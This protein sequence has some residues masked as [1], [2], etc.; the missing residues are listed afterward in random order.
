M[1]DIPTPTS[2]LEETRPIPEAAPIA[3]RA[4]TILWNFASLS[5]ASVF[6]RIAS[7]ATNAVLG[8]RI[9][10]SGYGVA[11]IAQTVTL[12]FSLLSELGLGTVAVRE[13][14]Q[15]PARLQCTISSMLGLRLVL[16]L[17]MIPFGLLTAQ[18]LPYS[19]SSRNLFRIY[20]FTLPIQAFEVEWVFR[21]VQ[22]MYLNTVL[23]VSASL[24]TFVLTVALIQDSR[25]LIRV[26]GIA[27][28]V[29]GATVAL[30][31]RLLHREG[32]NAWPEFS[33]REFRYLLGQS[34]PLCATSLAVTL[35]S[36]VNNL[37]LGYFR[38]D[39]DVGM[40]IA[41]TRLSWVCYSPMWF[42]FTAMAPA[43]S[44]AW[45]S[46]V[47]GARSLLSNSVRVSTT[48]SIGGGLVA[49]SVSQ[50]VIT[51][52][53][54]KTFSGAEGAFDILIWTGVV[55]AIGHNW[56]ELCVAAK[57]NR[58]LMQATCLGACVNLV[59]C[60]VTVSRMGIRGAAFSNLLAEIALHIFLVVSFGSHMGWSV[61]RNALRP[62]G[63]GAVAYLVMLMTRT[64]GISLCPIFT[65]LS[66]LV[67][68]IMIGG[69]TAH[70]LN[71]LRAMMPV[72]RF[73]PDSAT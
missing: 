47:D 71:K 19:E 24:L 63:A 66:Y 39:S 5:A 67:V 51:R 2:V 11:G 15:N 50:W 9:S 37:I 16:A 31:I 64:S 45:A 25:N 68:L 12:Y 21:S 46:S 72:R 14:A 13:G 42:Y 65:A 29:A 58:L 33:V 4:K 36:Q 54:G 55:I 28:I 53:F 70:D 57:R 6:S 30:G 1:S 56:G 27:A 18:F 22:K 48:I 10:A 49:A 69:V 41:A 43:L 38:S 61:L 20:L 40:Y 17:A 7:L 60:T 44:E 23:Q 35:Y 3:S 26:A 32:F 34:L 59:V 8:R 52:I 62:L 73:V